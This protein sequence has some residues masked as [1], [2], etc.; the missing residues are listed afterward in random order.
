VALHEAG[1]VSI[2]AFDIAGRRVLA[3]DLGMLPAGRHA[4]DVPGGAALAPGVYR[5]RARTGPHAAE[6]V[7][8][9]VR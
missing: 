2:E 4:L 1:E 8:V 6:R 9:K 5:I 7:L 3:A